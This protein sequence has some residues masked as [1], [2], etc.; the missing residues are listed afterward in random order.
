MRI[1]RATTLSR[2]LCTSGS[3]A[4]SSL[5]G[6]SVSQKATSLINVSS[7]VVFQIED[8]TSAFEARYLGKITILLK[9]VIIV[10]SLIGSVS[11]ENTARN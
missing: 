3:A 11:S 9:V 1:T 8:K 10:T 4:S 2:N 6:R 7:T 5:D